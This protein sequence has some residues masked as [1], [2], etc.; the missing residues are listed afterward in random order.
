MYNR[1][2]VSDGPI[3][4][5]DVQCNGTETSL[6]ECSHSDWRVH[7]CRH[8]EDVAVS[9]LAPTEITGVCV[10]VF[11]IILSSFIII[12]FIIIEIVLEAHKH[13][14]TCKIE[15]EKKRK[16]THKVNTQIK[17]TNTS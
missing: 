15:K 12:I 1:Y 17:L 6:D 7:N 14:H 9:C 4:L 16:N 8:T 11:I 5:D 3:W 2:G 13:I 10:F